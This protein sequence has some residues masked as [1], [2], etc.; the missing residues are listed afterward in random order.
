M[1][2]TPFPN[3]GFAK[4]STGNST[5]SGKPYGRL[6][7][8]TQFEKSRKKNTRSEVKTKIQCSGIAAGAKK[9]QGLAPREVNMFYIG[10]IT[11][12]IF[13]LARQWKIVLAVLG[14]LY[15]VETVGLKDPLIKFGKEAYTLTA[16]KIEAQIEKWQ[17]QENHEEKNLNLIKQQNNLFQKQYIRIKIQCYT[18][19]IKKRECYDRKRIQIN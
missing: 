1:N 7:R 9:N 8:I 19:Y 14:V 10:I 16:E 3:T 13:A 12:L 6:N 15:L 18:I 2:L 11:W 17:A 4:T 5:W